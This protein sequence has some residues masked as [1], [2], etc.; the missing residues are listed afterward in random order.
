VAVSLLGRLLGRAASR[1]LQLSSRRR[2]RLDLSVPAGK[3]D[4]VR[5]AVEQWLQG[6]G[7]SAPV[8]VRSEGSG[9][10]RLSV[11][12][13]GDD[14]KLLDFSDKDVQSDLEDVLFKA[15]KQS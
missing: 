13:D 6:Y 8:T 4:V 2:E 9:D 12:L 10:P 11:E 3:V 15:L 5:P 7:V 14:A 1:N